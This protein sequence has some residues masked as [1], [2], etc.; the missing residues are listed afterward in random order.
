MTFLIA[1][2][3]V[4]GVTL[5]FW[6]LVLVVGRLFFKVSSLRRKDDENFA[7]TE[8]RKE[9]N[10]PERKWL[11]SQNIEEIN[12]V[13]FDHLNLKGYFIKNKTNKLAILVHGYHGRYY[14]LT[15]QAKFL[16]EDGYNLLLINNRCH[17]TSEGSFI[18]MGK[19]ETKD[20]K[21][22]V[23]LMINRNK[24][25][26]ILLFG[27][28]MGAH[29]VM[30]TLDEN[31]PNVKCVVS[32]CGYASTYAQME[33]SCSLSKLKLTKFITWCG[34]V[35]SIL[36][37]H[38]SYHNNTKDSLKN[39]KTPILLMHGNIDTIVPFKNLEI[40]SNNVNKD[41]YSEIHVFDGCNHC[42]QIKIKG[43]EYKEVV[44]N[45]VDKFIK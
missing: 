40:N 7:K 44:L 34:N 28:S 21:Q 38:Y 31:N 1:L 20:L 41:T 13:S 8:P 16:Y 29:I 26:E 5:L 18:S 6:I 42:E 39:S 36:F 3:I 12:L 17:D 22:W 19:F 4:I 9:K 2:L 11:F 15:R 14:S 30:M 32:D 43:E 24:N 45:F 37:H 25:Y 35:Y 23:K 10:S 33:Y 27:V